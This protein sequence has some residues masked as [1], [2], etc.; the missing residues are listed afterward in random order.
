MRAMPGRVPLPF[1]FILTSFLI[2]LFMSPC[3]S[4]NVAWAADPIIPP[5]VEVN[6]GTGTD[7]PIIVAI[8]EEGAISLSALVAHEPKSHEECTISGPKW[9]WSAGNGTIQGRDDLPPTATE[10]EKL[11]TPAVSLLFKFTQPG[12]YTVS[13]RANATF[14]SSC[15][16]DQAA[17][18]GDISFT[19]IAV[20]VAK[21]QYRLNAESAFADVT[22][23]LTVPLGSS[24]EFKAVKA[25]ANAPAWPEGKPTW[26]SGEGDKGT[27]VSLT[28]DSGE[29]TTATFGT[30]ST[31]ASN[32][33]TV[34]VECGNSVTANVVV[35]TY[36]VATLSIIEVNGET[37]PAGWDGRVFRV[38][39]GGRTV[40]VEATIETIDPNKSGKSVYWSYDDPDE[41]SGHVPDDT[42]TMGGDNHGSPS[43][44]DRTFS[45]TDANGKARA[46]FTLS[47]YGGD[48]YKIKAAKD[49]MGTGAKLSQTITVWKRIVFERPDSLVGYSNDFSLISNEMTQIYVQIEEIPGTGD[50]ID[51]NAPEFDVITGA[52]GPYDPDAGTTDVEIES[53]ISDYNDQVTNSP[54]GLGDFQNIGLRAEAVN[55]N[56]I[57]NTSKEPYNA[58]TSYTFGTVTAPDGGQVI[59]VNN[60][61]DMSL[62]QAAVGITHM[63]SLHRLLWICAYQDEAAAE[64]LLIGT[65][66][67]QRLKRTLLHEVG[68]ALELSHTAPGDDP[69]SVMHSR[70]ALTSQARIFRAR[71]L[72][73]NIHWST[74][75]ATLVRRD[76]R[77]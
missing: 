76:W 16:A 69:T 19:V 23:P 1:S 53:L 32:F 70:P 21:L 72:A 55:V 60:L 43:N 45:T 48:N 41:P 14:K 4:R 64:A 22:G 31:T 65:T 62:D 39:N 15:T 49:L 59:D 7:E 5:S 25:P 24:I 18:P 3:V 56:H 12:T 58:S 67:T 10:E 73:L 77:G 33:K 66:K 51:P 52:Y 63:A 75:E 54:S 35:V 20:S 30:A 74:N 46:I 29:V 50:A 44:F 9:S 37:T 2:S 57:S 11:D 68:H 8:N 47:D 36:T 26:S 71:E 42:D 6:S 13:A 61:G 38:S 27:G 17:A 40:K 34:A 28:N